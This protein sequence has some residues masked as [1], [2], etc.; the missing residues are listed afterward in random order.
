M[1]DL[2]SGTLPFTPALAGGDSPRQPVQDGSKGAIPGGLLHPGAIDQPTFK[3]E[4][5]KSQ[6]VANAPAIAAEP[7]P[8]ANTTLS[9]A[10]F[11]AL[12]A[13][14]PAS[15]KSSREPS[16]F[17]R[18]HPAS[19]FL[20][21]PI[22]QSLEAKSAGPGHAARESDF[23]GSKAALEAETAFAA[24]PAPVDAIILHRLPD[25][26]ELEALRGK[27]WRVVEDPQSRALFF[28]PDGQFGLDDFIDLINPLQ[29]IPLLNIAYRK[30]TGDEI[31]GAPQLLGSI[32]F[33]PLS[34]MA[35]VA[36]LAVKSTTGASMAENTIAAVF[37]SPDESTA[38]TSPSQPQIAMLRTGNE[39]G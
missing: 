1:S 31:A 3:A 8:G 25:K 24:L 38:A 5:A 13:R 11:Q 29:H 35:N 23:S 27:K 4:L 34:V 16:A 36:D 37:G 28:G 18:Q 22:G 33:G 10:Q 26:D 19:S 12:I 7:L 15:A 9:P 30:L 2:L 17:E 14:S 32:V 21:A 6:A 20:P 39:R